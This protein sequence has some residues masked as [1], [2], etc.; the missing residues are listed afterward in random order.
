MNGI[1]RYIDHLLRPYHNIIDVSERKKELM[2]GLDRQAEAFRQQGYDHDEIE[3]LI[4]RSLHHLWHQIEKEI[5]VDKTQFVKK[6][7]LHFMRYLFI[8]LLFMVPGILA[9]GKL[10]FP[11]IILGLIFFCLLSYLMANKNTGTL[12]IN[13]YLLNHRK[14]E[15]LALW[16]IFLFINSIVCT[17]EYQDGT[18]IF[19][20]Y[21]IDLYYPLATLFIPLSLYKLDRVLSKL[22]GECKSLKERK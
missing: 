20:Q 10:W 15:F 2:E 9:G 21:M 7:R 22:V 19:K 4:K 3:G 14:R 1:E 6:S 11:L 5:V 18:L 8:T 17:T 12:Q 13:V 16:I